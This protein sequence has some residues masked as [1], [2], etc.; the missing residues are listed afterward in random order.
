MRKSLLTLSV[1]LALPILAAS[2]ARADALIDFGTGAAGKG[3]TISYAGGAA[4]LVG[5]G[6]RI[7]VVTGVDTPLNNDDGHDIV[8][9]FVPYGILNFTTGAFQGYMG[10]TYSFGPGGSFQLYGNV[11]DAGITGSGDGALLFSGAFDSASIGKT[12]GLDLFSAMGVDTQENPLLVSYFGLAPA[13]LFEFSSYIMSMGTMTGGNAFS[14][15]AFSTDWANPDPPSVE[16]TSE[17]VAPEP[18][19]LLLLG[20]GLAMVGRAA[21]RNRRKASQA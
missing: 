10:G 18:T 11:P 6:I 7:G 14:V 5:T 16:A 13:T 9:E 17:A 3:G 20:S 8:G 21:K 4:P 12:G 2:T 1:A 19:S 15:S